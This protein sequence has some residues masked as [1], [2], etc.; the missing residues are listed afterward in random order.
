MHCFWPCFLWGD[1]SVFN[2]I[3]VSIC[4]HYGFGMPLSDLNG[5]LAVCVCV[6]FNE[7]SKS[8]PLAAMTPS[9]ITESLFF[10]SWV[11]IVT[12][13]VTCCVVCSPI[14]GTAG[15]SAAYYFMETSYDIGWLVCVVLNRSGEW[16]TTTS[17]S[18]V[19]Q[20]LCGEGN[21]LLMKCHGWIV[22]KWESWRVNLFL[23]MLSFLFPVDVHFY[24]QLGRGTS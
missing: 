14:G 10:N 6:V 1:V 18:G 16:M 11:E 13:I 21:N 9:Q 20:K 8:V 7:D 2:M 4:F 12:H 24:P 3:P 17:A 22:V 23:F 19:A 15:I 5:S